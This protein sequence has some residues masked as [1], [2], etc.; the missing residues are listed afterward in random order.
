MFR[1]DS[2]VSFYWV[3]KSPRQAPPSVPQHHLSP[4]FHQA[5]QLLCEQY[6]P[7]LLLEVG[8]RTVPD[9]QPHLNGT[10]S[11]F[12]GLPGSNADLGVN[13]NS[14]FPRVIQSDRSC[15]RSSAASEA[16]VHAFV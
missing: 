8:L 9:L 12:L 1:C 2:S 6:S 7:Y 11:G 13:Y 10:T 16:F 14:C 4:S 3:S 15:P 5:L